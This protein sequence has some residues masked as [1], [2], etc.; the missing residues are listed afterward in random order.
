[1]CV[2]VSV[3][4]EEREG[5]RG[6]CV[7]VRMRERG[8]GEKKGGEWKRD[9]SVFFKLLALVPLSLFSPLGGQADHMSHPGH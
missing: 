3:C 8:S 1:M 2:C 7:G 4:E 5:E 6:V 9:S